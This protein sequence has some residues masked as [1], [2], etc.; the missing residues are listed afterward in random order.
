MKLIFD[1][2]NSHTGKLTVL[3][4]YTIEDVSYATDNCGRPVDIEVVCD[5][6]I[7]DEIAEKYC[8]LG[9]NYSKEHRSALFGRLESFSVE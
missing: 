6:A 3:D 5:E 2:Y 7:A 8:T 4:E 1:T 9:Y